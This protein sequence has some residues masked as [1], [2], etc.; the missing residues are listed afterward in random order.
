MMKRHLL[1]LT[2]AFALA[3][4]LGLALA[5]PFLLSASPQPAAPASLAPADSPPAPSLAFEG[6]IHAVGTGMSALW[7]IDDFPVTVVSTTN[8]ISNGLVARPGVWARVEAIKLVGLQATTLAL[9]TVPTSDLYNRIEVLDHVLGRWR[10]GNTWVKVG[11]DTLVTGPPPAVGNLALVH[12]TRS[13]SGIDAIRILVVAADAE[14]V[15]QGT[16]DLIGPTIW[17]V[18]DVTVEIAPTTVFSGAMP[19]LGSQVQVRGTETGPRRLRAAHIWTLEGANP[20]VSLAGWLQRIDGQA[21]PY[22]W[23]VNSLDGPNLRSVFVA[24]YEDTLVD[25]TAGPAAPGAW[26]A[27]EA[28]YQG[29]AFYRAHSIAILPR[30]PKRQIVGQIAALPANSLMGIWQVS[31]YRVEVGPATGIVGTPRLG[32]MVWASG[33]PDYANIVQAQLIEVL[34]E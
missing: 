19:A 2:A 28:V 18:D 7:V 25:E 14:V 3:L 10:V 23:R 32:A 31:G 11:P 13:G 22:L 27:I 20:Q 1:T 6:M 8:I 21:F 29:N 24:V 15:Y 9:Q 4:L 16:L 17:R 34:G 30:A 5:L 33:T 26:L 12:G